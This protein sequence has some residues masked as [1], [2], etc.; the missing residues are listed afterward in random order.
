[1]KIFPHHSSVGFAQPHAPVFQPSRKNRAF[2][3]VE[4]L[5]VMAIIS[6]MVGLS[7][8]A[9]SGV[10]KGRNLDNAGNFVMNL[11]QQARQNSAAKNSLTALV[12]ASPDA[13]SGP[14]IFC[15]MELAPGA[16]AWS[17]ASPWQMLPD[18]V[19]VDSGESAGFLASPAVSPG[20]S[21][22]RFRGQAVAGT[23]YYQVF[24]PDGS[25]YSGLPARLR[26]VSSP[27]AAGNYYDVRLN[28]F[29]GVPQAERP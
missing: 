2:S 1:M 22:L 10:S 15:L 4:L 27:A 18:G 7:T 21:N 3:L 9:V 20:L 14:K 24:N 5:A 16:A 25:L 8:V 28:A 29:T 26:L 13:A 11:A 6:V 17:Q 19:A 12:L 23:V